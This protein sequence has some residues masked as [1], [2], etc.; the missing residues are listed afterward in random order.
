M[1]GFGGHEPDQL[2]QVLVCDSEDGAVASGAD[3][4][5]QPFAVGV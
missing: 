2:L 5:H 1:V 4:E 3:P